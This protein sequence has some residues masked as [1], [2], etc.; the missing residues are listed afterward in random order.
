MISD[1]KLLTQVYISLDLEQQTFTNI[2]TQTIHYLYRPQIFA[3]IHKYNSP[4]KHLSD[5]TITIGIV[6]QKHA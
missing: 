6:G 4:T 1:K 5:K 3:F 2:K